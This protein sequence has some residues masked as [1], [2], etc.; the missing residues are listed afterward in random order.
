[1]GT[2]A[3]IFFLC[4]YSAWSHPSIQITPEEVATTAK[5]ATTNLNRKQSLA[6]IVEELK[7]VG[8]KEQDFEKKVDAMQSG[9]VDVARYK[10]EKPF[11]V[12]EPGAGLIRDMPVFLAPSQ[13]YVHAGRGAVRVLVREDDGN[14]KLK[15][16]EEEKA[17]GRRVPRPRGAGRSP[18]GAAPG[19][20][21]RARSGALAA[22]E[23]KKEDEEEERRKQGA[24]A[25]IEDVKKDDDKPA[26]VAEASADKY[27]T[28]L[29]G[30]R[31]VT[32]VGRFD[33]KAQKENY[34]KA[35]KVDT[36]S[37]D[38]QYKLAWKS[39]ARN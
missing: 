3:L 34:A 31:F 33:H 2:V 15:P 27:E 4:A 9:T 17:T 5:D 22:A 30:F 35:L 26:E 20:G 14:F 6:T 7:K 24:L 32:A 8:V 36:A 11:V 16:E 23:K 38:P 21:K 39:N 29:R 1:M 12:P 28:K 19:A 13:L 18:M 10:L 37:A 25:G